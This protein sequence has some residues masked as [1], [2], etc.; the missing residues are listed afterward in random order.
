MSRLLRKL[1]YAVAGSVLAALAVLAT[2]L[3]NGCTR[4][5]YVGDA[6]SPPQIH[7]GEGDVKRH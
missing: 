3:A 5:L 7:A 4:A 6:S 2:S 1:R